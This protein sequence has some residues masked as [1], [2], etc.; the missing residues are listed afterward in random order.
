MYI[1]GLFNAPRIGE[2]SQKFPGREKKINKWIRSQNGFELLISNAK[3]Y[4]EKGLQVRVKII[5]N[6][7]FYALSSHKSN[8]GWSKNTFNIIGAQ[9]IYLSGIY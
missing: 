5:S 4:H 3:L 8:V 1:T 6:L 2:S 9:K 7:E